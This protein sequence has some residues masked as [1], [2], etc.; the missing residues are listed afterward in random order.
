MPAAP[1]CQTIQTIKV[2]Y[3]YYPSCDVLMDLKPLAMVEEFSPVIN[4]LNCR[5]KIVV[6]LLL[7]LEGPQRSLARPSLEHEAETDRLFR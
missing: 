4:A 2:E 7:K 5:I 1:A 3:P 6:Q